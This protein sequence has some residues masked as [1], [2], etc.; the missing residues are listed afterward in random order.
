MRNIEVFL[1]AYGNLRRVGLLRRHA[2]AGR[3]RVTYEHDEK[4]LEMP[5][6]FQFDP[7]LPLTRGIHSI[8]SQ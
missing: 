7:S 1:D 6:A 2:G 4:W 3:E 5:E 8:S